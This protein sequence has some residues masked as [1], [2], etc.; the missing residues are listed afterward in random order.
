MVEVSNSALND[1]H[2][3]ADLNEEAGPTRNTQQRMCSQLSHL[4]PNG[5]V[6]SL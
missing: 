2:F 3:V 6:A 4:D 1:D 5:F